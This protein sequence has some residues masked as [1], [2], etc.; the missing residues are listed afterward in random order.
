MQ[1][2]VGLAI[3]VD[4]VFVQAN[5]TLDPPSDVLYSSPWQPSTTIFIKLDVDVATDVDRN[6]EIIA[7]IAL[8]RQNFLLV[9]YFWKACQEVLIFIKNKGFL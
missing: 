4:D 3:R 1:V 8:S 6:C 2:L 7:I 9:P 5:A